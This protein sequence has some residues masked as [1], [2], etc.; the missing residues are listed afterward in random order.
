LAGNG[1]MPP[2]SAGRG[3]AIL[4]NVKKHVLHLPLTAS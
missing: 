4:Q 2:P 3:L 1:V